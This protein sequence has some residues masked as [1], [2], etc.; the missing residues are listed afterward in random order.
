V[1]SHF[2]LLDRERKKPGEMR[3]R[4]PISVTDC[5]QITNLPEDTQIFKGRTT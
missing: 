1:R 4:L 2:Y 3:I 5:S